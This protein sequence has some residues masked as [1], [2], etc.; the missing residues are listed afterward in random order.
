MME[1]TIREAQSQDIDRMLI[2]LEE[3]FSIEKDFVFNASENRKGLEMLMADTKDKVLFIASCQKQ[4]VGMCSVQAILSTAEGQKVGVVEDL[5]VDKRFRRNRI[6]SSLISTIERW[7][8]KRDIK[9]LQ[10]LADKNN[11]IALDFYRG[12][13][14]SKT[15]LICL[16]K[17]VED[18]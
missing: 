7:A 15:Q 9:R 13:G 2:L 14:W 3:L 12:S 16:R 17:Y 4:I 10:L 11:N 1:I 8:L 5:V 18:I 6:A